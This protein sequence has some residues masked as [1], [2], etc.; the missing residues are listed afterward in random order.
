MHITLGVGKKLTMLTGMLLM[1]GG[2]VVL[3][4]ITLVVL[5]ARTARGQ[6]VL[7]S[8]KRRVPPRLR[9]HLKRALMLISGE[10]LFPRLPPSVYSA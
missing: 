6:R 3:L 7:Y 8:V 1:P 4:A 9:V 5:L 2:L 10:K